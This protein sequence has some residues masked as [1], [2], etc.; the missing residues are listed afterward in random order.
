MV[1]WLLIELLPLRAIAFVVLLGVLLQFG[2]VDIVGLLMTEL[3]D[4]FLN[5]LTQEFSSNLWPW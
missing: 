4:P 1:Y 5:W 3:V 2:G